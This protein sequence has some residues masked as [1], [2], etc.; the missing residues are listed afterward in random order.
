MNKFI[1]RYHPAEGWKWEKFGWDVGDQRWKRYETSDV[2]FENEAAA[3][4][5][6]KDEGAR[7]GI[8]YRDNVEGSY[9]AP[10]VVG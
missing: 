10:G 1:T 9:A 2:V 8:P 3:I 7:E 6:A 4:T 5:A